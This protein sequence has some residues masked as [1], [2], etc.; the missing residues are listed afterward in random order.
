[1]APRQKN[2]LSDAERQATIHELLQEQMCLAIRRTFITVLEEEVNGFI[3]AA[4]YQRTPERRD[5]RNGY[6]ERD[7]VTTSGEIEDLPVPRTRNRFRTQLFERYQRRQAEMD[8]E[9]R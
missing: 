3:R 8:C 7:L 5:Y 6:Y 4:L 9:K 2:T 1:M